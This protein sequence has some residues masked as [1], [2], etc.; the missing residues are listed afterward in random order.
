M[1]FITDVIETKLMHR[2]KKIRFSYILMSMKCFHLQT[3][4]SLTSVSN[5]IC[6]ILIL[7]WRKTNK[8][9]IFL[10]LTSCLSITKMCSPLSFGNHPY[11]STMTLE[12]VQLQKPVLTYH[13]FLPFSTVINPYLLPTYLWP[14]SSPYSQPQTYPNKLSLPQTLAIV[15]QSPPR[16][17]CD[18]RSW[19]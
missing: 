16:P 13:P 4:P 17:S 2:L 7:G 12:Q 1:Y 8:F 14:S 9:I 11:L 6:L 5:V 18:T 10:Q 3:N 15:W 19:G